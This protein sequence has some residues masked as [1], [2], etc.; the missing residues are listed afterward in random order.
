[1]Y[2]RKGRGR[3]PLFTPEQKQQIRQWAKDFPR[4]ITRI[5][6]LIQE[7]F[8]IKAHKDT[9]RNILKELHFSWHRIR[10]VPKG[11]PDAQLYQEKKKALDTFKTQEDC[12]EIDL[13][14]FD[15]SGFCLVPYLPYAWQEKDAPLHLRT[16]AHSK[17]LNV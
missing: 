8:S 7:Q 13:R 1:M 10:R 14:Y 16:D 3:P 6:L 11:E 12:G 15:A 5:R 2:E 9:I 4:N 17:R